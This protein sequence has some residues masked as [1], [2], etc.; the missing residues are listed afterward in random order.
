MRFSVSEVWP[1]IKGQTSWHVCALLPDVL[2]YLTKIS[3]R[4][5]D[6]K[7]FLLSAQ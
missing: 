6:T 7:S 2:A 3:F 5:G 1:H 4:P